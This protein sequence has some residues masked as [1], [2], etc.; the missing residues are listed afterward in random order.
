MIDVSLSNMAVYIGTVYCMSIRESVPAKP[1][2]SNTTNFTIFYH[3]TKRRNRQNLG[4][5]LATTLVNTVH[6]D[7]KNVT[8]HSLI[9]HNQC[10]SDVPAL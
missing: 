3:N 1:V 5:L 2:I 7:E 4:V 8:I 9:D 6:L 10:D